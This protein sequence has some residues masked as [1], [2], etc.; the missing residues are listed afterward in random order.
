MR[1]FFYYYYI[2][3]YIVLIGAGVIAVVL[4]ISVSRLKRRLADAED[5]STAMKSK[6]AEVEG[7]LKNLRRDSILSRNNFNER[8]GRIERLLEREGVDLEEIEEVR[9][10][11]LPEPPEEPRAVPEAEKGKE[12]RERV[13]PIREEPAAADTRPVPPRRP[14]PRE[15]ARRPPSPLLDQQWWAW[16]EE[17][18]G[19]RWMTWAGALALFI[20][21]GFF[22]K[23]AFDNQWLGP[24]GRVVLGIVAGLA[25]AAAGDYCVRRDMRALGQG[26]IGGASA[27]LYISLFAAFAFYRLIPQ[28][29]AFAAMVAVTAAGMSLA[30]LH[31]AAALAFLAVLGGFLTPLM[32]STGLDPRDALFSY[33]V[34][35]D[36]GVLGVA[37][38]KRWR[39]LDIL[40]FAGTWALFSGWYFTFY[41]S[42]ALT[43][44]LAWVTIFFLI[45]LVVPFAYQLRTAASSK[46]ESFVLALA[47]AMLTFGYCYVMLEYKY[48]F[49]LGFVALAMAASYIILA[50]LLRRRIP[51]DA[52]TLFGFVGLSVVFLTLAVP[53]HL[54]LHGI[55]MAWAVE[56]PV[57]AYL[58][59]VYRYRPVRIA[60][61]IVLV[62]AVLRLFLAHWPLHREMYVLFFNRQ[63]A[64]ALFVPLA[65]AAYA[66]IHHRWA[67]GADYW[68]RL[69]ST[70][71]TV[72]AGLLLLVILDG[73]AGR[74]LQYK[75]VELKWHKTY[76]SSSA[77]VVIWAL[78]SIGFLGW[79]L[80]SESR[81]YYYAGLVVL[82]WAALVSLGAYS[83]SSRASYIIFIN[84]RFL[85][86]LTVIFALAAFLWATKA[87][88]PFFA[89]DRL[90][91]RHILLAAAGIFPLALISAEAYH[92][93]IENI[94]PRRKAR[95]SGQMALSIVW[96]LYA[97][98]SLIVGFSQRL[99]PLRM[100]ALGLLAVTAVKLLL[101]DLAN[102]QQIYRIVSFVVLGLTMIAASY[103]YHRLEKL[104][105]ESSGGEA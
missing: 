91:V 38:F 77:T 88:G 23:Y 34:L 53:L 29:A 28:A 71:A 20:S 75:A 65:A 22:L 36:L 84:I 90:P 12:P 6:I 92:Y 103:L 94:R 30:V 44:T 40:A 55:T 72:A 86:G 31:N 8:L 9:L 45:F 5:R 64:A 7:L 67:S 93:C 1:L 39:S 69:L 81:V 96:G 24:T 78:G 100:A 60:G 51:D 11:D 73:E 61:F 56:G 14:H 58:G 105:G 3:T 33:L 4:F 66:L 25:M 32:L 42:S 49:V 99:R 70:T 13:P 47:N 21:A 104:P 83:S 102:V 95:W 85:A 52:R 50:V 97:V 98:L 76:L 37:V 87:Y 35:L 46:V 82:L 15:A 80:R 41:S 74:W 2:G 79:A 27:I 19:K 17:T 62:L 10:V 54:K 59:Y 16:F 18:V 68:D 101:I 48:R 63:F 26:L 43:P 57:L 89:S